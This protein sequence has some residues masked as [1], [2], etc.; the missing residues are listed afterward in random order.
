MANWFAWMLF[1][2]N[3]FNYYRQVTTSVF[4]S[5]QL[6]HSL[7]LS[8]FK[9]GYFFD[10]IFNLDEYNLEEYD[11]GLDQKDQWVPFSH[12]TLSY[13]IVHQ[14]SPSRCWLTTQYSVTVETP[15]WGSSGAETSGG[16]RGKVPALLFHFIVLIPRQCQIFLYCSPFGT[17]NDNC[18]HVINIFL[19]ITLRNQW[20]IPVCSSLMPVLNLR[21]NTVSSIHLYSLLCVA[22][23]RTLMVKRHGFPVRVFTSMLDF[24]H[25]I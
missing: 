1:V 9:S 10:V 18:K 22:S 15:F 21:Q 17:F 5:F 13:V 19:R 24:A 14:P 11:T 8:L 12:G 4:T 6:K 23:S 20:G 3:F 16:G 25:Y 2:F 7:F